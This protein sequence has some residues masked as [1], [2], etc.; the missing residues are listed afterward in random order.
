[1]AYSANAYGTFS[2]RTDHRLNLS[3]YVATQDAANNRSKL[4]WGLYAERIGPWYGS[5]NNGSFGYSVNVGGNITNGSASLPFS[6]N[7]WQLQLRTGEHWFN[8]DGNGYLTVYFSALMANA[9]QFGSAQTPT[10]RL[11]ADRIEPTIPPVAAPDAPTPI[12][13]DQIA[14]TSVRYRFSGNGDGG[15]PIREWQIGYGLDPNS[16]QFLTSS[17]GTS[18]IGGL[19]PAAD[20]YFWARGRNDVGWGAFSARTSARTLAGGTVRFG[21]SPRNSTP[22]VRF[23][24]AWRRA[25]PFGKRDGTW[26][27]TA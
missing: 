16:P 21:G 20:Y 10:T 1:M 22:Y 17:S 6:S 13:V 7:N 8:H 14:S 18:T 4:A 25:R 11:D 5:Y 19:T 26:R 24:G 23:N 3:V 9:D 2:G 27:Y 15:T 12:G